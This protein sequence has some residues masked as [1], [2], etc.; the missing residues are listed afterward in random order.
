M[1]KYK[2]LCSL[3]LLMEFMRS[4]KTAIIALTPGVVTRG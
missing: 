3:H 4:A 2:K 1:Q